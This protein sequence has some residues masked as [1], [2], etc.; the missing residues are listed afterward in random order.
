MCTGVCSYT[1]IATLAYFSTLHVCNVCVRVLLSVEVHPLCIREW[2][3]LGWL[4]ET[5]NF[6]TVWWNQTCSLALIMLYMYGESKCQ[7][8]GY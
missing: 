7:E 3:N 2:P 6:S 4:E 8:C 1:Y 5:F